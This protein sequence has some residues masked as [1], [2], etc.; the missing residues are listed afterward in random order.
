M[1]SSHW[2]SGLGGW[3]L[4]ILLIA[5]VVDDSLF[6]S[7]AA[8]RR[9][10]TIRSTRDGSHQPAYVI[11]PESFDPHDPPRPLLVS[12]HTWSGDVQQRNRELERLA[13]EAGWIYLFPH[14]RGPNQHPEACGSEL[15]QQDIL[16]AV[17]WVREQYPVDA[18]RIYL[19]GASGG[20]HMT[21]LM[22]GRYPELWAAASAWVPITDLSDWHAQHAGGRYGAMLRA[23][24]GGAPGDSPA[25]D[26]EYR[27]RSPITHIHRAVDVPL[28]IAA[29]IRDGH[30]GSVPI[31]HSLQAFN[32]L[33]AAAGE[34]GISERELVEL[35]R[36]DGRLTAPL[37]S[38]E[39]VDRVWQRRYYLRRHAGRARVTIFDGGHEGLAAGAIDWLQ[40]HRRQDSTA[41]SVESVR[42]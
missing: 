11:L 13:D 34:P 7:Q 32:R 17:A 25:V 16:D 12:L 37:P 19:T 40:R 20:G 2:F 42:N 27:Q 29:G 30:E 18:N 41:A 36:P 23:S 24:C 14:F 1:V 8:V 6:T 9:Q 28:D 26:Q 10:V 21:L 31:R 35:S 38:D 5:A 39:G 4:L 22:V 3:L 15:A 33:A